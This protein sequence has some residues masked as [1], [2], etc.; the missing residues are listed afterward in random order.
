MYLHDV[1]FERTI[2]ISPKICN[3]QNFCLKD[4]MPCFE[5][6]K[7]RLITLLLPSVFLSSDLQVFHLPPGRWNQFLLM[8]GV[9]EGG[10]RKKTIVT[11]SLQLRSS[12]WK[13]EP[14]PPSGWSIRVRR[15]EENYRYHHT[16]LQ[17]FHLPAGRWSQFLLVAGVSE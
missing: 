15:E 7:K 10:W 12:S 16:D 13:M 14:V 17:V 6:K 9:S 3:L 8:A 11:S 1:L 2:I 4:G 5:N